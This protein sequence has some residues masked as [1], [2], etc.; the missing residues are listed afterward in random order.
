MGVGA[1]GAGAGGAVSGVVDTLPS[2]IGC[3]YCEGAG[4]VGAA[5]IVD[6]GSGWVTGAAAGRLEVEDEAC[7]DPL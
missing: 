2:S 7:V 5:G 3:K 6:L 1:T 4:V